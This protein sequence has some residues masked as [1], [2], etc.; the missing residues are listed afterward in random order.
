M[1]LTQIK[2]R[3]RESAAVRNRTRAPPCPVDRPSPAPACRAAFLSLNPYRYPQAPSPSRKPDSVKA[4]RQRSPYSPQ[5][6][7]NAAMRSRWSHCETIGS[8]LTPASCI[9]VA[10]GITRRRRRCLTLVPSATTSRTVNRAC[11]KRRRRTGR[12]GDRTV[13]KAVHPLEALFR[14]GFLLKCRAHEVDQS[15]Q[16]L[17]GAAVRHPRR[18][19]S[20]AAASPH[21]LDPPVPGPKHRGDALRRPAPFARPDGLLR[22]PCRAPSRLRWGEAWA[23]HHRQGA[24]RRWSPDERHTD[25]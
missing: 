16:I 14:W 15:A 25:A 5:T 11:R 9:I 6:S 12:R 13:E 3:A 18:S 23:H 8:A 10:S 24:S 4:S 19:P 20:T 2:V 1:L 22:R 7:S 17:S 21:R